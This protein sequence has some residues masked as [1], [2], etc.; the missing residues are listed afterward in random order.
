M[1][2]NKKTPQKELAIFLGVTEA[3]ISGYKKTPL[4]ERKLK[5]MLKGLQKIN[6]EKELR[7]KS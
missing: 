3:T 4:G 2:K 1:I 5:L 6:E 7:Q